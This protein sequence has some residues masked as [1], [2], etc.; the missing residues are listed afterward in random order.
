M[1]VESQSPS[2]TGTQR[3]SFYR[4]VISQWIDDKDASIFVVAG[5]ERDKQVFFEA[6]FRNVV[7]SNLDSRMSDSEVSP[8]HWS[9]QN[10]EKLNYQDGEFDYTV[11][12]AALHHCSSPHRALLEMYRVARRAVIMI[13]NRDSLLLRLLEKL[14]FTTSY[15]TTA[16]Y[17]NDCQYG[18]VNNTEIPNFIYR[19]TEREIRKTISSYTPHA[20]HH[21]QFKYG[22][23]IPHLGLHQRRGGVRT[24]IARIA[25]PAYKVFARVFP[26]QQNL[27]GCR[28]EKPVLPQDL[29]FWVILDGEG[30]LRFNK[31]WAD[32]VY[33]P[34][35]GGR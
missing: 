25:T 29:H 34:T 24:L 27:L 21:I 18:G 35:L 9:F 10:A 12:H 33:K 32:E 14:K 16:V 13:E 5:G 30:Q 11:V 6:G 26:T 28:I 8:Y 1:T 7:I 3:I 23:D 22:H 17:Y 31:D 15:E 19:W 2:R 4:N 20:R